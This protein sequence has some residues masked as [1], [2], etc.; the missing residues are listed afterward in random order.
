L[1]GF[2]VCMMSSGVASSILKYRNKE[3]HQRK[4]LD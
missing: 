2:G 3:G 4:H 1:K